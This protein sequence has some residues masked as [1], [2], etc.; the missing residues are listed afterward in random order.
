MQRAKTRAL[1]DR[2]AGANLFQ[3]TLSQIPSFFGRMMYLAS[4]R[5]PHTGTYRHHGFASAF[6]TVKSQEALRKSHVKTFRHW[7]NLSLKERKADLQLYL[8]TL[9]DPNGLVVSYWMESRGYLHCIPDAAGKA[10]REH[11]GTDMEQLLRMF[12]RSAAAAPQGPS[13]SPRR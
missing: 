12:N 6:G 3:R 4:L 13:S 5:D 11:Y 10:A 8:D 9:D 7:L 1:L 2:S